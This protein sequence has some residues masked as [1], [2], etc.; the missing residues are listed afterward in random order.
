MF[1][2]APGEPQ[3]RKL[4]RH[5]ERTPLCV[6]HRRAGHALRPASWP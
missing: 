6:R 5:A 4:D 2:R 1:A 3:R